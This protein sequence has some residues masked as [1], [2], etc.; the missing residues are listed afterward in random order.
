MFWVTLEACRELGV[1]LKLEEACTQFCFP[2]GCLLQPD[3]GKVLWVGPG[4]S[5]ERMSREGRSR[6][7]S[8]VLSLAICLQ[9]D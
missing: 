8:E 2:W 9:L 4:S 1:Q 5:W 7:D 6:L 3:P